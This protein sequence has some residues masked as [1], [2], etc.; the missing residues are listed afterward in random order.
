VLLQERLQL[1]V[2][3]RCLVQEN[4]QLA[5]MVGR[6]S[7]ALREAQA[8]GGTAAASGVLGHH[9]QAQPK[10][11]KPPLSRQNSAPARSTLARQG[12]QEAAAAA[13]SAHAAFLQQQGRQQ[14]QQPHQQQQRLLVRQFSL[15]PSRPVLSRQQQQQLYHQLVSSSSDSASNASGCDATFSPE[16][17]L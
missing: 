9:L 2:R 13:A 16:D 1:A 10:H 4:S 15:D 14:Q 11:H 8:S 5:E 6:L 17:E 7:L 3:H 12:S